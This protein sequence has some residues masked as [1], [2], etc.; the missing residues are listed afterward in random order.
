[1][2]MSML[3]E[4]MVSITSP[5]FGNFA[6]LV[7]VVTA[8]ESLKRAL[9]GKDINTVLRWTSVHAMR[10]VPEEQIKSLAL[11]KIK[12]SERGGLL[13]WEEY[14][15]A[16]QSFHRHFTVKYICL[17]QTEIFNREMAME[18]QSCGVIVIGQPGIGALFLLVVLNPNP[19]KS[20]GFHPKQ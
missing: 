14:E 18:A 15:A 10:Y 19:G 13:I 9:W 1:M 8:A 16:L 11:K 2:F 3:I 20:I 5:K 17:A 7:E 6:D 12:F 4:V